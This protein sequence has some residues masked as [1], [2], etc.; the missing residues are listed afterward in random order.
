MKPAHLIEAPAPRHKP[1]RGSQVAP[2]ERREIQRLYLVEGLAK[3]AIAIKTCRTRETIAD[4]LKGEDFERL[5]QEVEADLVESVRRK[6]KNNVGRAADGWIK[7]ID[8]AAAKGD[9]KPAKDLLLHTDVIR[10][11]GEASTHNVTV[12]VG[13]PGRQGLMPPT[14]AQIIEA[15]R[16]EEARRLRTEGEQHAPIEAARPARLE[17]APKESDT[18]AD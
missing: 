14:Q 2:N 16:L 15:E 3:A 13:M 17:A 1:G 10:P 6:L 7:A 8:K 4:V 5:R 12:I 9:H 18:E 11:A